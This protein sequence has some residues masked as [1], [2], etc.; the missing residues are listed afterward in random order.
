MPGDTLRLQF[1][2]RIFEVHQTMLLVE[3]ASRNL[4]IANPDISLRNRGGKLIEW[5][6][7]VILPIG[8]W[9][10]WLQISTVFQKSV[11]KVG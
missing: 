7:N 5:I 11:V 3:A 2:T 10:T 9:S 4:G 1:L 8:L 6:V